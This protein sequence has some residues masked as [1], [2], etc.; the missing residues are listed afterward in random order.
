MS[1]AAD[2]Y[3]GVRRRLFAGDENEDLRSLVA[4]GELAQAQVD[5]ARAEQE[6]RRRAG[7][8]VGLAQVLLKRGW[9]SV[10]RFLELLAQ[11]EAPP[12]EGAPR[13]GRYV[14]VRQ[15]ARGGMGV[16]YEA[17]DETLRRRVA[18][19]LLR[20]ARGGPD[21]VARLWR[22]AEIAA[23]LRHPNIVAIHEIGSVPD[24]LGGEAHFIAM[25]YVEGGTLADAIRREPRERLLRMLVDVARAAEFA[26]ANGVVHRDLK[27]ANVLVDP[28]GRVVLTD[29]G[30][31][32]TVEGGIR[33]TREGA[34]VGTPQYMAP[35]QVDGLGKIDARADV[36]A[37][38]VM[39][40]ELLTGLPAFAAGSS[41]E[42]FEKIL[43]EAPP[44]PSA[45]RA[46]VERDL[47]AVCLKAME[48]ERGRRYATAAEFADDL[49]RFLN[50]EPV[51]ARRTGT[52]VRVA[53]W[54]SRR[55]IAVGLVALIAAV[56]GVVG[57]TMVGLGRRAADH[58]QRRHV[59]EAA[60]PLERAIRDARAMFHVKAVDVAPHLERVRQAVEALEAL[61]AR[62]GGAAVRPELRTWIGIGRYL[63]GDGAG[64]EAALRTG[65]ARAEA[66]LGRLYM[67][68]SLTALVRHQDFDAEEA[69]RSSAAWAEKA[70]T[71]L[72]R[73]DETDVEAVEKLS[74]RAYLAVARGDTAEVLRLCDEG[75]RTFPRQLGAEHFPLL[76]GWVSPP[77]ESVDAYTRAIDRR[78]HY[79][80]A[81]FLRGAARRALGDRAGARKDY[82]AALA[83]NPRAAEVLVNRAALTDDA[84]AA[85][86]DYDRA[87]ELD[88][89]DP[90]AWYGRGSTHVKA[91]DVEG[92]I[93]DLT[94]TVQLRPR[95]APAYINRGWAKALKRDF[96]GAMAD[97]EEGL[98]L[99]PERPEGY[100]NRGNVRLVIGD[101][102]GALK[103]LDRAINIDRACE[104]AWFIRGNAKYQHGD[105][106][107]AVADWTEAIRLNP[108]RAESHAQ[109]GGV[110]LKSR[111]WAEARADFDAALKL[112]ERP[113][114]LANR[115]AARGMQGDARGAAEDFGRAL[116]IA[117]VDWP[118]RAATEKNLEEAKKRM[119]K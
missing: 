39:L 82:D 36:Y 73:A 92:A 66:W 119:P 43:R 4:R 33:L 109:R 72:E 3:E 102:V 88:A 114:W 55:R 10:A 58:E 106:D 16:V 115:G 110:H 86:A 5:E 112:A 53:R 31:A 30:L 52:V 97:L 95:F 17:R 22:E 2:A 20:N 44:P 54:V 13:L 60:E 103:D 71:C 108:K 116:E 76:R 67:E 48:K 50:R 14:L 91:G 83:V 104:E 35:E 111:R 51:R 28:T 78:P 38:G 24:P 79:P 27:P 7:E 74:A 21:L 113:A 12:P 57:S 75:E 41:Q 40:Y 70:R 101:P 34:V 96:D 25:D 56:A 63:L 94:R 19:K 42:L 99:A 68:R 118:M 85:I 69:R 98:R 47:D 6:Q 89:T 45:R 93:S 46:G 9:L 32:R 100:V 15:V 8:S 49:E 1:T 77:A 117:P 64:A 26:H 18:L 105:P 11:R 62:P 65:D 81:Y 59:L 80:L 87:I 37:L 23:R 61:E 107:G 29:F 84:A 90:A